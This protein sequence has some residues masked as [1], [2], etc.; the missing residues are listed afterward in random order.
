VKPESDTR[1]PGFGFLSRLPWKRL[2]FWAGFIGVLA[3]LRDFLDIL[4][5]TFV[6]SF[7]CGNA[8]AF[9]GR[10][11]DHDESP[12]LRRA[13]IIGFYGLVAGL[14]TVGISI[15]YPYFLD[16]GKAML[17]RVGDVSMWA[18]VEEPG[19][20]LSPPAPPGE[21][22]APAEGPL[23]ASPGQTPTHLGKWP[24]E[25]VEKLFWRFLGQ[26]E[27]DRFRESSVYTATLGITQN[28]LNAV[29]PQLT[30]QLGRVL[31][32]FLRYVVIFFLA[33]VLSLILTLEQPRLR[34]LFA[35]LEETRVGA[36]YREIKPSVVA[37]AN[38]LGKAFA[39]QALI[40]V[41]NTALTAL[42]LAILGIPNG[43]VLCGIVFVCSFI[44]VL[45]VILSTVPIALSA[46]KGGGGLLVLYAVLWIAG[47]H[48]LKVYLLYPRLVGSFMR[49]HPLIAIVILV[50]AEKLFGLWGLIL[51][52]PVSY[53]LYHHWVIGDDEAIAQ[54][55]IGPFG[56]RAR[57]ETGSA[58][59]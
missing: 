47:V 36:F 8:C 28:L 45:G 4:L 51:G 21:A 29:M 39:T 31:E 50:A 25:R 41:V 15:T 20:P 55:P 57:T 10:V 5:L 17:K 32:D 33:L 49:V 43:F 24:K 14:A 3:L 30:Q 19:S 44:P 18:P 1:E 37:F 16:Q 58:G 38:I 7:I 2:A 56:K 9:M 54:L 23:F 46:L 6:L 13:R 40:A 12:G 11:F 53:Y 59:A 35:D 26:E 27:F 52:V 34:E 22:S 42:G 48:A